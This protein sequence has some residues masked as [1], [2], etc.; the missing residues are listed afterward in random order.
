M[1]V[2]L[3]GER[4]GLSA[5]HSLGAYITGSPTPGLTDA[6]RNCVPNIQAAGLSYE[7]AA[8][9]IAWLARQGL[10]RGLTGV[11]LKDE[12]GLRAVIAPT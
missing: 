6:D 1:T 8:I 7:E 5:P 12:S 3:N 11:A 10:A 2:L 9:K 4:P